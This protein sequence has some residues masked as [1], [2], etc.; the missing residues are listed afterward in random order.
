MQSLSDLSLLPTSHKAL[1]V[2]LHRARLN[3]EVRGRTKLNLYCQVYLG[4]QIQKT[5]SDNKND[6]EPTW[7]E[8]LTFNRESETHLVIEIRN[9]NLIFLSKYIGECIIDLNEVPIKDSAFLKHDIKDGEKVIGMLELALK[10]E[11]APIRS[12]TQKKTDAGNFPSISIQPEIREFFQKGQAEKHDGHIVVLRP[13]LPPQFVT[14]QD[15]DTNC[16]VTAGV[17]E[18][19]IVEE[20]FDNEPNDPTLPNEKRCIICLKRAK[21]GVFYRCGHNC[22]CNTCG[23]GLIGSPC[24]VCNKHIDDFV[25]VYRT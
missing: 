11:L 14:I 22:C 15:G 5:V 2:V 1:G 8:Y 16:L 7:N 9:K 24:P 17:N 20:E 12:L 10:W 23:R 3:D 19:G 4:K 13:D 18:S 6:Y 21:A 25:K